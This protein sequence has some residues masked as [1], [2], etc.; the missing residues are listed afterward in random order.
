MQA[1]KIVARVQYVECPAC[2]D[3]VEGFLGDPRGAGE[4]DD[5]IKC[6]KCGQEFGIPNDAL[7]ELS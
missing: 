5:K 1:T 7:V 2:G 4:D 6:D 3:Y